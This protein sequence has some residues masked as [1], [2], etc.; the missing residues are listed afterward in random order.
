MDESDCE[1]IGE[2][3]CGMGVEVSL[4]QDGKGPQLAGKLPM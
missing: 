3:E 4:E 2:P 1:R